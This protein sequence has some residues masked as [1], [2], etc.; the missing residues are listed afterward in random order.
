[1]MA[2]PV[3]ITQ[4]TPFLQRLAICASRYTKNKQR[5]TVKVTITKY[6]GTS[7]GS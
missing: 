5:Q 2:S 7:Y 6:R 3:Y 4:E 1:M